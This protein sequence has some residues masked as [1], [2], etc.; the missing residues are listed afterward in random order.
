[1]QRILFAVFFYSRVILASISDKSWW[2]F[3]RHTSA[4]LCHELSC[5]VLGS[6]C[7][8]GK[9]LGDQF[10][11]S[12]LSYL[13]SLEQAER[14]CSN[15]ILLIKTDYWNLGE[16]KKNL[17][18]SIIEELY[19]AIGMFLSVHE[20]ND[21]YCAL[22]KLSSIITCWLIRTKTNKRKKKYSHVQNSKT[23]SNPK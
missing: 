21:E 8:A 1:M 14:V 5:R 3:M 22:E 12:F 15:V 7:P 9:P 11:F 2:N 23:C 20:R 10:D 18:C 13:F 6:K 17:Y 19:N 16:R 4:D